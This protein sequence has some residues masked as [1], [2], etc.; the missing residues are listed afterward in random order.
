MTSERSVRL[1][2]AIELP[3]VWLDALQSLQERMKDALAADNRIGEVRVRWV[4]PEGIHLTLKFIGNISPERL[5]PIET[6]LVAAVPEP[7]GIQLRLG[8]AG[9]F[10]D[11]R[12]PRVLWAGIETPQLPRLLQLAESIETWLAAAGVPRER[13]PFA[14]HLTL[15]RLPDDVRDEQKR[16]I[17]EVTRGVE[18][19]SV[20]PFTVDHVSLM[21]SHIGPGGA[22]YE[23]VAAYP[24]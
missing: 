10:A 20:A 7:P 8:R 23:R 4:K 9:S 14:P 15:A 11:R 6:Q 3:Q 16:R 19:E 18:G 2:V 12:A 17:A 24:T 22:R 21:R 1:F 5:E 13:R